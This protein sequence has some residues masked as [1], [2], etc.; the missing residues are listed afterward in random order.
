MPKKILVLNGSP[1]RNL[2]ATMNITNAFLEGLN[3]D[4][5]FDIEII[6]LRDLN[7]KPCMGCLSCWGKSEGS[8]VIKDDDLEM[9]KNKILSADIFIESFP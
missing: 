2:S 3:S 8:C 7:I 6:N 9:I 1:K 5:D 4:N